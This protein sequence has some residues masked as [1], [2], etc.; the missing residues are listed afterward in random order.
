M[1]IWILTEWREDQLKDISFGLLG[2]GRPIADAFSG[3][4]SALVIGEK[5]TDE[6]EKLFAY[7]ADDVIQIKP[8]AKRIYWPHLL[9]DLIFRLIK[10]SQP[11]LILF[12]S[13]HF[14]NEVAG[15][16]SMLCESGLVTNASRIEIENSEVIIVKNTYGERVENRLRIRKDPQ[17][18]TLKPKELQAIEPIEGRKGSLIQPQVD[19]DMDDTIEIKDYVPG[20]P[21]DLDIREADFIIAGG[22]GFGGKGEFESTYQLSDLLEA[23]VGGSREA[24]DRYGLPYGRQIGQTGKTV[25][26]RC[27]ITLG[28][29]GAIQFVK[30]T[31]DAQFIV[32]I[33]RDRKAPIFNVADVKILGDVHEIVPVLIKQMEQV[34]KSQ[35][36]S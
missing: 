8:P 19:L 27:L 2:E 33:N 26:P 9:S 34:K 21:R 17:L 14:G 35:E 11:G 12:A 23:S 4:L 36:R 25:S 30:G 1:G 29:S 13:S 31:T 32:A 16:L 3:S 6:I 24:V 15:R 20:D 18:V 28:I 5:P 7:G 10:E 22:K